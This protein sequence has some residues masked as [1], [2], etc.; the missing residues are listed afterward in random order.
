MSNMIVGE[1]IAEKTD[2]QAIF[3]SDSL[4]QNFNVAYFAARSRKAELPISYEKNK[5]NKSNENPSPR[6]PK[7][8]YTGKE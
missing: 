2:L 3:Q 1:N 4:Q 6:L 5:K 7:E 8:S